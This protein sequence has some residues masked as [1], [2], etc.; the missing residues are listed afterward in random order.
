MSL[1]GLRHTQSRH[2]H[3]SV[4]GAIADALKVLDRFL[5]DADA[6]MTIAQ[7]RRNVLDEQKSWADDFRSTN[8]S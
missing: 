7:D 3:Y 2:R 5:D 4:L 8:H 6:V 1:P